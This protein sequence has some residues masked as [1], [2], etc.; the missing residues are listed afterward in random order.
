MERLSLS[1]DRREQFLDVTD[2]VAGAVRTLDVEEGA[3]VVPVP[4]AYLAGQEGALIRHLDGGS[5][6]W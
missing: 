5:G 4:V 1:T 6:R 2:M 3:V